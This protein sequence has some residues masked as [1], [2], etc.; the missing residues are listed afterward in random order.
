M[1]S[2][3]FI[4]GQNLKKKRSDAI[5]FFVLITLATV[6]L[7]TSISVFTGMDKV[8]DRA[9]ESARTADLLFMSN[10]DAE[11][12]KEIMTSQEEVVEYEASDCLY[13][14]DSEYRGEEEEETKQAQIFFGKIDEERAIG[15]I[16]GIDSMEVEYNSV[17]LP[18]Y[19][20]AAEGFKVGDVC[21]FTIGDK[22]YKFTIAGFCEDPLFA[23]PTNVSVYGA[24]ISSACMADMIKEN[25]TAEAS[26]YVQHKVRLK[27]GEN[28]FEFDQKLT[29]IFTQELPELANTTNIGVNWESMRGGVGMMSGISMG[30][31]LVFSL[32]LILVVLIII[33]FSIRNHIEMNLKNVGILQAAGYTSRQLNFS[34]LIE[35]GIVAM[36]SVI[37]GIVL[38]VAGSSVIGGFEGVM[39][40]LSWTQTWSLK[41]LCLT[42]VIIMGTVLSVAFLCGRIYKKISVLEA[43]RGGIRTHNFKKNH[44]GFDK[45]KMPVSLALAGKN[46]MNEKAKNLSV[47]CIVMILAFSACMGFGL[48]ENFAV[49]KDALLKMV[50]VE[51]GDLIIAGGDMEAIGEELEGW[52][53]IESVLYYSGISL[54]LESKEEETSVSCDVWKD[55]ALARNEMV[56]DGRLPIYDNEIV[57]TNNIAKILDVEVG[58]T[59]YVTGQGERMNYIVCGIDQK[60]N[61]MGLKALMSQE[62]AKRLNG[63]NQAFFLYLYTKDDV[64]YE[65]MSKKLLDNYPDMSMTDSEKSVVS[66]MNSVVM[67][68]VAICV[69]FVV[70]TIFVVAMVEVLLVKSKI[71]RE[72]KNLGLNKALGFTTGQLVL[73]TMLM[74]LPMITFGAVCGTI[75][76]NYLMEPMVLICLSFCGIEKC[77]FTI[78]FGWMVVT[79]VGIIVV[80]AAASLFSAVKIRNIEP[81]KM[82]TEE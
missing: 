65:H 58:D 69:I 16:T 24:Y 49:R 44:F 14:L 27:E 75:L 57:V 25:K 47:F 22:E 67:A 68:M 13:L 32:L 10:V 38:G 74:N 2:L 41:S 31:L 78:N 51:S 53:E 6:L 18:Y 54:K 5:V 82:L 21:Y 34:V 73:Q 37:A 66:I 70:I 45:T 30:I 80:A 29:T 72:R 48:Y 1:K 9:Y 23:T 50:G 60:I 63:S 15:K 81:V 12:I 71:I 56:I 11:K 79:V 7:Y 17:V 8:I 42:V 46:L 19:M 28:S 43:L 76:S 62:G 20:K 55:P 36:T 3:F 77:P 52:E 64:T 4:A 26:K 61:N 35:M 59:I 33:R 39:L 40:G